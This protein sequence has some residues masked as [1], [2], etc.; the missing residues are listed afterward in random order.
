MCEKRIDV[1]EQF[2]IWRFRHVKAVQRIIG[3]KRRTDGTAGS[4]F[5][6]QP[7]DATFFPDL[8]DV[9]TESRGS[10]PAGPRARPARAAHPRQTR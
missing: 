4:G 6:K 5:L 1:D 3:A 7:V 8:W 10:C 9:R 2:A